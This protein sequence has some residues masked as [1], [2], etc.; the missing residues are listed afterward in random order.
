MV[1]MGGVDFY[2]IHGVWRAVCLKE[3]VLSPLALNGW[4]LLWPIVQH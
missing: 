1:V 3:I 2:C 4:M